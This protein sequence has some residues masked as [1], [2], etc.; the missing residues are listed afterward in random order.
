LSA[1]G[2]REDG[3]GE[4]E[5]LEFG[6]GFFL[7]VCRYFVCELLVNCWDEKKVVKK[8]LATN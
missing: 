6:F 1:D 4:G 7:L 8:I 5:F 2:V 3:V